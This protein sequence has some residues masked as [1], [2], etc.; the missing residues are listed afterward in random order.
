MGENYYIGLDI[1]TDSVGW[2]VTD[3]NYN[4]LSYKKKS[5]W[6]V[7]LFDEGKTAADRRTFRSSRRRLDRKK[8]RIKWLQE[9]FSEEISKIDGSFYLRLKDSALWIDD[10]QTDSEY[11]IFCDKNY[12]DK[13]YHKEF[14]TIYH[15]RKALIENKKEYDVR[16]VYLAIHNILKHR[17]HFLFEGNMESIASFQV[18]Y[19]DFL[20]YLR[21][22]WDINL[23]EVCAERFEEILKDKSI[24]VLTKKSKLISLCAV[25]KEEKQLRAILGL[26]AGKKEK[27]MEVFDDEQLK[28]IEITS[29]AFS[30]ASYEEERLSL[31]DIIQERGILLDKL[32]AIYDWTVLSDILN[33]GDFNGKKFISVSKVKTYE[34]HKKDLTLLKKVIKK[35]CPE[36]YKYVFKVYDD[37]VNNYASYVGVHKEN[38]KSA[39]IKKC[40]KENFYKFIEGLLRK[41]DVEDDNVKYLLNKIENGTFLPLQICSDNGIIPNQVHKMELLVILDNASKYLPF[42]LKK[43]ENGILVKDKIIKLF[44]FRIPY[45]VGPLNSAHKEQGANCWLK[46]KEEGKIF[47][48]N[49]EQMVD[50]DKSA[51]RFISRMTNSCTYLDGKN[52]LPKNSLLYTEFVVWNELNNVKIRDEKL[53]IGLKQQIYHELFKKQKRVTGK[54]LIDFLRKEGY[55]VVVDELTGF[56]QDFKAS[57]GAFHDFRKIL[58]EK[59]ELESTRNM[60]EQIIFW[61]TI[62]SDG[63]RILKNKVKEVYGDKLT[64][65]E[66]KKIC[67]LKYSGWGKLS[68]EFLQ[69]VYGSR[70]GDDKRKSIIQALRNGSDNLM[71]LLSQQYTYGDEILAIN[72]K[73]KRMIENVTYEELIK[74]LYVSTSVKRSIW[75]TVLIT[76]EIKKIMQNEP[77][78][79]FIEMSRGQEEKKRTV[80][81]KNQLI[82]LYKSIG[83]DEVEGFNHLFENIV[84]TDESKFQNQKLYLYYTQLGRCMYTG[85]AISIEELDN[86]NIYDR[87]HIY[88]QSKTKDDSII[89]NLVLVQKNINSE[90]KDNIVPLDIQKKMEPMWRFLRNKKLISEE[91]YRRLTRKEPLTEEELAGF[92]NRQLVE[93]RQSTK[94][95]ATVLDN[96]YKTSEIVYVKANTVSDFK[97]DYVKRVKVRE[98]NDYHHGK[99]AFLNIVVGNV[100][101]TKFTKNPLKWLKDNPRN[102]YSLNRMF[103]FNLSDGDNIV[104]KRGKD[105][106][107][108][109]IQ[110][111]MN[112]NDLLFTRYSY[113][114]KGELFNQQMV[115]AGKGK[116]AIKKN[117]LLENMQRY[118]GY[119]SVKAAYF[120]LVESRYKGKLRRTIETVPLYLENQF[121]NS[122][123]FAVAYCKEKLKLEEPR[124]IL[125]RIKKKA[126]IIINGFPM[127]ITGHTGVQ[128]GLQGAAQLVVT[129]EYE[130]YLKKVY[131]YL[132]KHTN[133]RDKKTIL[134]CTP[135]DGIEECKNIQ[136]YGMLLEK[137]KNTIYAKRPCSC[138][139][140]LE[141]GREKFVAL[142][143]EEQCIVLGEIMHLFQC[144]PFTADLVRIGGVANSGRMQIGKEIS[145]YDSV[146]LINQSPTGIFQQ[147]IDLL[148]V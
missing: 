50:V 113:C 61:M 129:Q 76:E 35:Y 119:D 128:I 75:Q 81:R 54:Q 104:W 49:F 57:L 34:K 146:K 141:N 26:L 33:D 48:W 52:V 56:D 1:G 90:K 143:K 32:K 53:P 67:R 84:N 101:H 65:E 14:P 25:N 72:Q 36:Q 38:C 24:S 2:A 118:G 45:Y 95:V 47:P 145:N 140:K 107:I 63:G 44:E 96:L 123:E 135:Y 78:K 70:R 91:K 117:S 122:V 97:K 109:S 16:L 58:K 102:E 134:A 71:Q 55:S 42:L 124:I 9:L 98:L 130:E 87:D 10:K 132:E 15:L 106:T 29:V 111:T 11:S 74:D 108:V 94:A 6:G 144:K 68:R 100:Y 93:A 136:V 28:E 147:E 5:L 66:I 13:E 86:S 125:P 103:D 110:E 51:E 31:D 46:R 43:D 127:H 112:K 73:N 59:I 23:D 82:E 12:T 27:L 7:R 41:I 18:I 80:S 99:D 3:E 126:K 137:H 139:K 121:D 62:Y 131:K 60:V 115:R 17:G 19:E 4:I 83:Q 21:E 148:K 79:I 105:G 20:E 89:N 116:V 77:K 8:Q 69:E 114:E 138:I 92:I 88:P 64:E 142:S 133:R 85:K 120:M 37:K 22:E 30:A 39:Y 40:S